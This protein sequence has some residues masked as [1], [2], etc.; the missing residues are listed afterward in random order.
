MTN[1]AHKRVQALEVQIMFDPNRLAQHAL[2]QAYL[3]LVPISRRSLPT[4]GRTSEGVVTSQ[5]T[6]EER[7]AL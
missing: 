6:Q 1:H 2:H 5:V 4:P 3:C 7:G